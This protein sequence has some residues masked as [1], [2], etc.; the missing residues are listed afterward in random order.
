VQPGDN[1]PRCRRAA[2]KLKAKEL[3]EFLKPFA[4]PK[5]GAA[6][7][8]GKPASKA[9]STG[10]TK[11]STGE[12][13]KPFADQD[14]AGGAKA[15]SAGAAKG[16]QE[17]AEKAEQ[18]QDPVSAVVD[19]TADDLP[20]VLEGDDAWLFGV[21]DGEI[22]VPA[23]RAGQTD[24]LPLAQAHRSVSYSKQDVLNIQGLDTETFVALVQVLRVPNA[25][26][27]EPIWCRWQPT[28]VV[29]P[30]CTDSQPFP[31]SCT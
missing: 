11:G 8:A 28:W 15:A 1:D 6:S 9:R 21:F 24:L 13:Q 7:D 19:L 22:P 10:S 17:A 23:G 29:R 3:V 20:T 16:K 26:P 30:R 18:V 4:G 2:G 12:A 31:R 5:G 14:A 25:M 27:R